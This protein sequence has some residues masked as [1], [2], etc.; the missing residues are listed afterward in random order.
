V[1]VAARPAAAFEAAVDAS[2]DGQLYD[3]ASP[4]GS[5]VV[6]RRRFTHM[7]S[8]R[9]W[10]IRL[11][12]RRESPEL[13]AVTRL[14][15]DMDLGQGGAERDPSRPDVFI[16]GLEQAPLDLMVAYVEGRGFVDDHVGFRLGRQYRIDSL[17]FWSFDGALLR[18]DTEAHVGVSAYGGFEQR[19]GLLTLSTSRFEADGVYRGDRRD[20]EPT[21]WPSYLDES[22]LAPAYGF[23]LHSVGPEWLDARIDYRR[24][25]NRDR[26]IVS[27]FAD[28][29]GALVR[30]SGDRTSSERVGAAAGVTAAGLGSLSGGAVVD[31]Y[32]QRTSELRADADWFAS[33]RVTFGAGYERYLSTYDGDSIFNW[34]SHGPITT[35][36]T[37]TRW[38]ASRRLNL[39]ARAG[40]RRFEVEAEA[41]EPTSASNATTA[42]AAPVKSA[43]WDAL[44][45]LSAA[46]LLPV[47]ETSVLVGGEGGAR[48]HRYGAD[49]SLRLRPERTVDALLLLSIHRWAD[50]LRPAR[51][52][53]GFTYVAGA[54]VRPF[55]LT[56]AGA[57]WEHSIN[58]LWG[59]R[60]RILVT[61]D[62]GIR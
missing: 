28:E 19:G 31:L 7:L 8:L 57:E 29:R 55:E 56:R 10:D 17:G 20:L 59:H 37:R 35:L 46:Y 62:V 32:V 60:F 12:E 11:S 33:E 2:F 61:L 49:A 48:G 42:A 39:G 3:M 13:T 44:G 52:A 14:R 5:P 58:R 34:F 54:G 41:E 6:A 4:Y 21:S 9:V 26:V 50:R 51:D 27:P 47:A 23:D 43:L 25:V 30:L 16:P 15:I 45:T 1:A 40:M 36:E 18:V 53:T 24:V 22:E 38:N